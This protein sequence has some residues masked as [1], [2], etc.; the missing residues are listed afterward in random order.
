MAASARTTDPDEKKYY[1]E[2][3]N[4]LTESGADT[5][6]KSTSLVRGTMGSDQSWYEPT[7]P[8]RPLDAAAGLVNH[9]RFGNIAANPD[10][11]QTLTS[12]TPS[13]SGSIGGKTRKYKKGKK[14]KKSRKPKKNKKTRKRRGGRKK[15]RKRRGGDPD[16]EREEEIYN[17]MIEKGLP[18]VVARNIAKQTSG[19]EKEERDKEIR[20]ILREIEEEE[21]EAREERQIEEEIRWRGRYGELW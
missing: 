1:T 16:K 17:L 13:S 14:G 11:I 5:T 3:V 8:E 12:F 10:I 6:L 7:E 4:L 18:D 20:R 19:L 9:A 2:V 15:T 21:R